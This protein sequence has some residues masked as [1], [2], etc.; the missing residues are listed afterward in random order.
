[1]HNPLISRRSFI[2]GTIGGVV[3]QS[4]LGTTV[5]AS[6][7]RQ[8]L[9]VTG[10]IGRQQL[11]V[12]LPHEHII[13]DFIG[14][15]QTGAHRWDRDSVVQRMLPY[16]DALKKAGV[17]SFFDCTPAYIG[18]D[19]IILKRLSKETGLN[20]VTNTGFYG[21]ANDKYVPAAAYSMSSDKMA[22][23][24][25]REYMDGIEG[26]GVRPGFIKIGV[27][28]V[29]DAEAPLSDIDAR[30]VRA[31]AKVSRETRLG[32]TCHTGGGHAGLAA[33]KLFIREGGN[34]SSFVVAHADSHGLDINRKV[35]DL[36]AW[37]SFDAVGRKPMKLHLKTV[38]AMLSHRPDRLLLSQDNGWYSVG[39]EEGGKV[40]GYTDLI[41][42]FLPALLAAGV[43]QKQLQ[44]LVSANPWT[45]FAI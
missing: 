43:A 19:P 22:A 28:S 16:V 40:R 24:W 6:E 30:I 23:R 11:G 17:N 39:E 38:P 9:T 12:A 27:D 25:K 31:A 3:G 14:A 10:Q 21:G 37:V 36:G 29:P 42:S 2:R 44:Q 15:N 4:L 26:T 41:Q 8:V 35:S 34:A 5:Q 45:A 20:I 7:M 32:V 1:M 33:V 18:R 13:C